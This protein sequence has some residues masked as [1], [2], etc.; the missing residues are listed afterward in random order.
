MCFAH[1]T[2]ADTALAAYN[3]A[4]VAVEERASGVVGY[5]LYCTNLSAE[6]L[7]FYRATCDHMKANN[8][9]LIIF[10]KECVT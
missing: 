1:P 9:D 8:M 5:G 3:V 2:I 6:H 10:A 7:S 4:Q